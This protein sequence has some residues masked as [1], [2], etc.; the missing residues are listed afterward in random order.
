M[1]GPE[2]E[3]IGVLPFA[4]ALQRAQEANLDLVEVAPQA[5][6]PVV[7]I[8]DYGRYKY[9]QDKRD[10][11]AHRKQRGGDLKG[12]RLTPHIGEHDFQVKAQAVHEFLKQG[13]KVRVAL[14]FRG[15]QVAYPKVGET[16]LQR[17]AQAVADVGAVESPPRL[18]GRNMIMVLAPRRT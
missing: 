17:L 6:P 9:E 5:Q 10:R 14:W 15:R 3:Q 2:G 11:Q 13:N 1:I 12:M 16:L 8:M 7:K 4:A 18:E